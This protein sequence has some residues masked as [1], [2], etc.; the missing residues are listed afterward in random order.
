M[1]HTYNR[2]NSRGAYCVCKPIEA[3]DGGE[4]HG[5]VSEGYGRVRD[6]TTLVA[7]MNMR[8]FEF[9]EAEG[10]LRFLGE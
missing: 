10:P 8:I 6:N 2:P 1:A 9:P 4:G 3:L 5:R 7:A